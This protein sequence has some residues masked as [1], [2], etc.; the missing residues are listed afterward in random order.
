M[1]VESVE[2][3]S[4]K[5]SRKVIDA[6]VDDG[7]LKTMRG[8]LPDI[9]TD[10]DAN[11]R[12]DVK[13]YLERRY[14]HDGK[15]RVFSAG[16]FTTLQ[17]KAVI[18]DV[19]RVHRVSQSMAN[20]IT[21]IIG[22][23]DVKDWTDLMK[24]AFKEKK[25]RDFIQKH[26]DVAE[27]IREI[28]FQP[29]AEGVHASALVITPD[30]ILG[31]DVECFD[32]IPIK[33]MDGL[34]V[35]ELS[36]VELDELGLLKNDVLGIAELSRLDEMIRICNKMYNA[37]LSIEHLA[38]SSLSEPKVFEII[39]K[40]LTQGIFQLSSD[41][42]TK[43]VKS[44][45]PDNINDVIAANALFRPATLDSGAA[46][47]YVRAKNGLTD[48][49]YLWGTY[50]ILKNTF[51]VMC[52]AYDSL[53][54]TNNGLEKIQDIEPNTYV[55]TEDGSYHIVLASMY[56]KYKQIISVR[57][58]FGM[59]IKCTPDHRV[60]TQR[61][62]VE[63]GKL[64]PKQDFIK[65]YWLT[66]DELPFG[67]MKDWCLGL[68]L[69]NGNY[70]Q[71]LNI[72]CRNERDAYIIADRFN[73]VFGLDCRVYFH[74][75]AWYVSLV[76]KKCYGSSQNAFKKYIKDMGLENMS[77]YDKNVKRWSLMM[78]SG[79]FE[80]DGCVQN[81]RIRI[82]NPKL[83]MQIFMAAQAAR[84]HSSYYEDIENNDIVYTI[85]LSSLDK[86]VFQF[87]EKNQFSFPSGHF[88]PTTCFESFDPKKIKDSEQ[89]KRFYKIRKTNY[90]RLSTVQN[91]GVD[92]E[93]ECWGR[94]L[95]I[96]D[97]GYEKTYDL[98][99]DKNHSF[100]VGG[101]VVHNCYQEDY[102][103]ISRKIGNL[104]LGDGVNLVKAISK[105]KVEK[106]RKFKDKFYAGA[107]K[108]GC[109]HEV[110]DRIWGIIEGG[111]S[112]GFNKSHATAYG[113][114][115]Y[116][117]AY[118]KALYPV[119]F[120]TVLLKWG[121]DENIAAILNEIKQL[122][123]VSISQPDIN[124]S[125]DN[126]ETNYQTNE[127]YWSLLR[128]KFVGVT[129]VDFI[130]SNRKRYGQFT[131]I[132]EFIERIFKHKFKKK[133]Q[134]WDDPDDE[135]D[136]ERCPVNARMVR[137]LIVA[138]AFDK[139][140]HVTEVTQRY[141]IIVRAAKTLG[142]EIPEKEVPEDLRD[143]HWFWSQQQ[144]NLSGF[145]TV[146][147]E[148][149]YNNAK[150]PASMGSY[151]YFPLELLADINLGERKVGVCAT[152]EEVEEKSYKDKKT[153]EKK[154]YGKI[155]LRQNLDAANLVIWN[156]AWANVKS[157]FMHKKDSIVIFAG[158]TKFSDY[159]EKNIL[160]INKNQF[161]TNI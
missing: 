31:D 152:I 36:G 67:D 118:L 111:A 26:W 131:C 46:G 138:G 143:K 33:K 107:Q 90:C 106:I 132:E 4:G 1:K 114:T 156:D 64:N 60:L 28:M 16:T 32:I 99:I 57:T 51:G 19:C 82:K 85:A 153:G 84:I 154:Y 134:Y 18:K 147:Y 110:A 93:H 133:Y 12:P 139:L 151:S 48:P 25:L 62:W 9:D 157:C 140:E 63:A 155:I 76:N 123:G 5:K 41:G 103:L 116:I 24:L 77:C 148:R 40:G 145:G 130:V 35:S 94:V 102:A 73:E 87:K 89:R 121:K 20:Y 15:Q 160:Q 137:N 65:C 91:Y 112:Y 69:A 86:L 27:E 95:S 75:R 61:G 45:N 159:D 71:T 108:N 14:N 124:I 17:V 100:V 83:A 117:G 11:K 38:T 39:N 105:K 135:V 52:I 55:Q 122:G 58:S 146:D 149:I 101:H 120:Y 141:D 115:A 142:F 125:T 104:S 3:H 81:G 113:I 126:F 66:D 47:E 150:L 98:S 80:G 68:Y 109:P 79:F 7:Y 56:K 128:V 13:A 119:A 30:I 21:A 23:D 49:E 136:Y 97:N 8:S 158:N 42:M 10:F 72:T 92:V 22:D 53:V 127:I 70:S 2:N 54:K 144:I 161:V 74:T 96:K 59:E 6:F 78:L 50:D 129:A 44:M 37:N 34:L 29:R 43:F 88:I